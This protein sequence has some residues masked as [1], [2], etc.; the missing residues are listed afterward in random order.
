M[1]T[2][3]GRRERRRGRGGRERR[4][5]D[6]RGEGEGQREERGREGREEENKRRWGR[7]GRRREEE[8]LGM[9]PLF[10]L[11]KGRKMQTQP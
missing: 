8:G 2:P 1:M 6:G 3:G 11:S 4:G 9:E 5:Q 7:R 10:T